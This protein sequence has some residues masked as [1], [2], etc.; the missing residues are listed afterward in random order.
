MNIFTFLSG[1]GFD[2][3]VHRSVISKITSEERYLKGHK[4]PESDAASLR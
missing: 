4:V 2:M 3:A 1:M